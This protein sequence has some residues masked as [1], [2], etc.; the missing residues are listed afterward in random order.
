MQLRFRSGIICVQM[1]LKGGLL[2]FAGWKPGRFSPLLKSKGAPAHAGASSVSVNRCDSAQPT[3]SPEPGFRG[4]TADAV[5][6][7]AAF[8]RWSRQP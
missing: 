3:A 1:D 2:H 6:N 7:I 8:P 4:L 5:Y